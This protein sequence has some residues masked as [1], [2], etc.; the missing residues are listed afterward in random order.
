MLVGS[1]SS[2]SSERFSVYIDSISTDAFSSYIDKC[3]EVGFT[4]NFLIFPQQRIKKLWRGFFMEKFFVGIGNTHKTKPNNIAKEKQVAIANYDEYDLDT[5]VDM[6]GNKGYSLMPEYLLGGMKQENFQSMQIFLLDFDGAQYNEK[7]KKYDGKDI[8]FDEIKARAEMYGLKVAFAYKTFSCPDTLQFFKYRIGFVHDFVIRDKNVATLIYQE[9]QRVFPE[10]D[11]ACTE[12]SRL[13]LGGKECFYYDR[14]AR[15]NLV[16]LNSIIYG[17]LDNNGNLN[18]NLKSLVK[19]TDIA[20]INNRI[21]V[22]AIETVSVFDEKCDS[23]YLN[24]LKE[25]SGFSSIFYISRKIEND[26]KL[27]HQ[28]KTSAKCE[29]HKLNLFHQS[30]VCKLL[31]DFS[32]G[33][34]MN[35]MERFLLVT[36][37]NYVV[38]G[39]DWFSKVIENH[40]EEK[41]FLKWMSDKKY[42]K[43]Y[44]P[45]KCSEAVCPYYKECMKTSCQTNL[46]GRLLNDRRIFVNDQKKY[47]TLSEATDLLAQNLDRAFH[48]NKK[49]IHIIRAQTALG[50]TTQ[51]VNLI[52]NNPDKKVLIAEPLNTM[53]REIYKELEIVCD[54]LAVTESVRE[55][56]FMSQ[57]EIQRYMGLHQM[58]RH[59]EA[60]MVVKECLQNWQENYPEALAAIDEMKKIL[61]G[62]RGCMDAKVVVTTHAMLINMDRELLEKFDAIIVDE[63]FLYLQIL[64]NSKRVSKVCLQNIVKSNHQDMYT[65]IAHKMLR[66]KPNTFYKSDWYYEFIPEYSLKKDDES[67]DIGEVLETDE[68]YFGE[69]FEDN[70]RDLLKAGAYV[71]IDEVFHYFCVSKL[72]EMK[73]IVL[74]ATSDAEVYRAYFKNSM[75]II[76]YSQIDVPYKGELKQFSYHSL[77]RSDLE[78]KQQIY[79][80]VA[81]Y[82]GSPDIAIIS[83]KKEEEKYQLNECNLHFGNAVGVNNLKG[84]DIAIIGTPFKNPVAYMLPCCYMYGS[85]FVNGDRLR[86]QRVTYKGRNFLLMAFSNET[87]RNFQMYSLESELEQCI[88]RARLLRYPCTVYLFSSFPCEQAKLNTD[89]YLKKYLEEESQADV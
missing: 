9:L 83:F 86:R 56:K 81:D 34:E 55:S 73:Y 52:K 24:I 45:M 41:T 60:K 7:K 58:G 8:S 26:L 20:I 27:L 40:Y 84:K 6:V 38:G 22:G 61:E 65:G 74:T 48:S 62:V 29:K 88:G 16:H 14:E 78:K 68:E 17:I 75:E 1:I 46:I 87:L 10:C 15:F 79:D 63:D 53:K 35:H 59:R 66:A 70:I 57:D 12:V 89:D 43:G 19:N 67:N 51:I 64:S 4:N 25:E 82:T 30:G 85:E 72:P 44:L 23:E 42:I 28:I 50:K 71:C 37:L 39:L 54:S 77:G 69:D 13:F 5:I 21:A 32:K 11:H 76:E 36:N 49:G 31:D 80:F 18:R 47:G 2:E 33:D 3:M